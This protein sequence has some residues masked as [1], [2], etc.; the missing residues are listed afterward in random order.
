MKTK[1]RCILILVQ[2]RLVAAV[3]AQLVRKKGIIP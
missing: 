2:I 3:L 1:P